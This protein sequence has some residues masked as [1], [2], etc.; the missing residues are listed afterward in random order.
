MQI[1]KVAPLELGRLDA[2]KDHRLRRPPDLES[3]LQEPAVE[4]HLFAAGIVRAFAAERRVE[5][6]DLLARRPANAE[7][8]TVEGGTW[9]GQRDCGVGAIELAQKS[10]QVVGE[11][12]RAFALEQDL[13]RAAK[14]VRGVIP[15]QPFERAQP[16]RLGRFVVVDEDQVVSPRFMQGAVAG[17]RQAEL[18]LAYHAYLPPRRPLLARQQGRGRIAARVVD[19]QQLPRRFRQVQLAQIGERAH[20]PVGVVVRAQGDG[21]G[22]AH[23]V[24]NGRRALARAM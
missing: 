24:G 23:R 5:G 4:I 15:D 10:Q 11:P 3:T 16:I 18:L 19:D 14:C 6:T 1:Q 9:L 12:R 20:Q 7:V 8:T 22:D 21:I 2:M 13:D 17:V